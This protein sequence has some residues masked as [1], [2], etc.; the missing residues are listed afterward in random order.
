MHL[1]LSRA[2][3]GGDPRDDKVT[4]LEHSTIYWK[5]FADARSPEGARRV[6][7]RVGKALDAVAQSMTVE[8]YPKTGGY[9]IAFESPVESRDWPDM[10]LQVLNRAQRIGYQWTLNG[11]I[12]E[13]LDIFTNRSS[14]SG[15]RL[16]QCRVRR[17]AIEP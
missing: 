6:S 11:S 13:E 8:P 7:E 1:G 2:P 16:I 17:S 15:V 3:H 5:I 10:I 4:P 14:I 9:T 12:L